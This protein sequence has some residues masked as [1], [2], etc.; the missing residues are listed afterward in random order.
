MEA[1]R[2]ALRSRKATPAAIA[3]YAGS[4]RIWSVIRP[5]LESAAADDT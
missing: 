4:L 2:M 5:Y 1:L 3:D